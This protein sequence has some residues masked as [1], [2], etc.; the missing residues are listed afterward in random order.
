MFHLPQRLPQG[1]DLSESVL[2]ACTPGRYGNTGGV[3]FYSNLSATVPQDTSPDA[4]LG[5]TRIA[6]V[7]AVVSPILG[8]SDLSFHLYGYVN[9]PNNTNAYYGE[10]CAQHMLS[11]NMGC[12]MI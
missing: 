8:R 11:I 3:Y 9:A 6:T 5:L 2:G 7:H 10:W 4:E 12:Y 1:R